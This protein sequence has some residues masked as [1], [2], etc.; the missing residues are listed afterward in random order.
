M[1][2]PKLTPYTGQVAN[3]DGSQTQTEFT[4]NMFDQLSYEAN[5]A[6]ELD[7]T[8]DGMNQAVVDTETSATNAQNAS[9]AAQAA[10]NFEGDFTVGVTNAIKGKS[11]LY[12]GDVWLCL[13]NTTT[14]PS[15][16]TAEWKLSVGEQYVTEAQEDFLQ[17]GSELFKG[18]DGVTVKNGDNITAGTTH[19]RVLVGGTPTIV[20]M[21]PIASGVVTLLTET[22]A[23]IGATT[24][25]FTK[26][27][28]TPTVGDMVALS[29]HVNTVIETL[30][31]YSEG[32]GGHGIYINRGQGWPVV[33]DGYVNHSDSAGNFLELIYADEGGI[34][35][36]QAGGKA[37]GDDNSFDNSQSFQAAA[38]VSEHVILDNKPE[39]FWFGTSVDLTD[40]PNGFRITC[41]GNSAIDNLGTKI[42][43]G[44]GSYALFDA[45]GSQRCKFS[46]FAILDSTHTPS[47][48][49]IYCG[50]STTNLFAQFNDFSDLYIN[51]GADDTA[52]GGYGR[53][54]VYSVASELQSYHNIY[55]I[56]NTPIALF[57]SNLA[58][59]Q[60][61][62]TTPDTTITSN[63]TFN[64]TGNCTLT[65]QGV[66]G[67]P[68]W[69]FGAQVVKGL[70][71]VFGKTGSVG[72]ARAVAV[73]AESFC[74]GFDLDVFAENVTHIMSYSNGLK[75]CKM[76]F[77]GPRNVNRNIIKTSAAFARIDRCEFTNV[78]TG[79]ISGQPDHFIK[80]DSGD[81][82][83]RTKVNIDFDPAVGVVN[84]Q[85]AN[86][87]DN[88]YLTPS[89]AY[90]A[91]TVGVAKATRVNMIADTVAGTGPSIVTYTGNPE[92]NISATTG[93][94]CISTDGNWYK[95]SGSGTFGWVIASV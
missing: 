6:T 93:S 2:I 90:A 58:N 72:D 73:R 88:T 50:R 25:S 34:R 28:D 47:S 38:N 42:W 92:G 79:S 68:L 74:Q 84:T 15:Q 69:C 21:S 83:A 12:S 10:A 17:P 5:L 16:G 55:M 85:G 37:L 22:G 94:I 8:I 26:K 81:V 9:D 27:T 20:A 52:N 3:P 48:V 31:Y 24:V 82:V 61:L 32:D 76:R 46:G 19:L 60:S 53:F 49:G 59:I 51:L 95:K 87:I 4:Q 36:L 91:M 77:F 41:N 62:Y 54:G 43:A 18:S 80:C 64:F 7:A 67:S 65:S 35:L 86:Q 13:Q 89:I 70:I 29:N 40:R 44:T 39:G 56:A 75:D 63:S 23:T 11:Y 14:T 1:T 30:G 57:R 33:A 71:Y 66:E 45:V 78:T